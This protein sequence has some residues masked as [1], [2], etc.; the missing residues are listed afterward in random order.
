MPLDGIA[1]SCIVN[2]LDKTLT[3]GRISK[4]VQP[5]GDELLLT[6]KTFDAQYKLLLSANPSLPLVCLTGMQKPAPKTAPAF[7]MYL[8]KHFG[9]GRITGITQPSLERVI[10]M[11]VE[12][13]D[14]M[15]DL[16]EKKLV[17]ELM[18]KHSNVIITD[19][20]DTILDS[21]K[22]V[23]ANM[24]SVREVLPGRPYFIPGADEKNDPLKTTAE[25]FASVLAEKS[26]PLAKAIYTSFTGF[27]PMMAEEVCVR[28]SVN[29]ERPANELNEAGLSHISNVFIRL[30][31]EIRNREYA[32]A[33]YY[34]H[35][36]PSEFC[37][38]SSVMYE[39]EKHTAF[40]SVSEL[41]QVYYSEKETYTRMRQKSADLRKI[42]GTIL[43]RNVKKAGIQ[44]KQL[45]S[46]EKK[47]KYRVYGELINT[48][49]YS[50]PEG[51]DILECVNYYDDQP[52]KIPLDP[53][54]SPQANAKKYFDRYNKLKRTEAAAQEQLAET[55]KSIEH[56][57]SIKTALDLASDERDL[58]DISAELKEYG[59]IR[60]G[61]GRDKKQGMRR[62]EPLKYISSDGFEI[63]V[64]KNNYQNEELSFR[65]AA[66]DDWWF[67][68]KNIPGS[69]VIVRCGG[70][71]L[72]DST[73]EEA[74][75]LAAHYSA[76][77]DAPKAEVDYT[78]RRNLKKPNGANPGFVIYHTNY[79]MMAETDISGMKS[80]DNN[81]GL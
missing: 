11:T 63:L 7:C 71:D 54:V 28:A 68:A 47:D 80:V 8:R 75:R 3:G 52:V 24:S 51:S 14:E 40:D 50:L 23:S 6:V 38:L 18:G 56:L 48:Y 77:K 30:I 10:V 64:G 43:E 58:A 55:L 25:E 31:E 46:T 21:I 9:N 45:K 32:P 15:G 27:S 41:L 44:Q 73:F 42:V 22:K 16:C 59:Y 67:H 78:L 76:A 61:A 62:S 33:I 34:E 65:I 4:I 17:I 60:K 57:S 70:R 36:R 53:A 1:V 35:G 79:S 39:N 20:E 26:L 69:H 72:P 49:G 66:P 74:A 37:V 81:K 2:E 5:E 13:R 29:S 12:H 19:M